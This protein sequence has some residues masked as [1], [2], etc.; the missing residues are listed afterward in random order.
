LV[1]GFVSCAF[2]CGGPMVFWWLLVMVISDVNGGWEQKS[3]RRDETLNT[4][5]TNVWAILVVC[6]LLPPNHL[7]PI[8]KLFIL[9]SRWDVVCLCIHW[10]VQNT[11]QHPFLIHADSVYTI[12]VLFLIFFTYM[13]CSHS[14]T[15]AT[16]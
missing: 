2:A 14:L 16:P 10:M 11:I 7:I 6:R 3:Y 15:C 1:G 13:V 8:E 12:C 9:F 5:P 4:T